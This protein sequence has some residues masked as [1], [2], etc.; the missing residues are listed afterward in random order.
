MMLQLIMMIDYSLAE[1]EFFILWEL[2]PERC[3]CIPV[4]LK[5]YRICNGNT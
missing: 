5:L 1:Y 4:S 2:S 3:A